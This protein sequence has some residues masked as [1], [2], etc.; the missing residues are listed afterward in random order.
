MELY[1]YIMLFIIFLLNVFNDVSFFFDLK[2]NCGRIYV[3][4]GYFYNNNLIR[5]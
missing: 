2:W 1:N 3:F 5:F 4:I